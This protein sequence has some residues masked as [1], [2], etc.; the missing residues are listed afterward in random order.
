MRSNISGDDLRNMRTFAG[1]TTKQMANRVKVSRNTYENWEK[2]VGQPKTTQFVTL[3]IYCGID[4]SGLM[5]QFLNISKIF[6]KDTEN[7]DKR[8]KQQ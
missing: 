2:G 1:K 5:N 4:I 7:N 8:I 6:N 3:C